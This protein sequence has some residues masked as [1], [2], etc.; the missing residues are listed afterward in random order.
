MNE[1]EISKISK[2]VKD[3]EHS[4]KDFTLNGKCSKCGEC[5]GSVI[6]INQE[7]VNR[8]QEYVVYHK[9]RPQKQILIMTNKLRCPYYNGQKCLIYEARPTI[10]REFVCNKKITNYENAKS[11]VEKKLMPVDMWKL[12]EAI[13][14]Q[15]VEYIKE[16]ENRER[17]Q[18]KKNLKSSKK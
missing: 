5:C 13:D 10:C 1:Y 15:T 2:I 9:V 16:E 18:S 17:C 8:L 12:A 6:P 7:D 14:E 3:T 4:I 11:L